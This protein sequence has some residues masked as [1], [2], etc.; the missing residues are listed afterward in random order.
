[1]MQCLTTNT[2]EEQSAHPLLIKTEKMVSNCLTKNFTIGN[3]GVPVC[4]EGYHMNHDG[5][6]LSKYRLK[7]RC[8]LASRKYDCS[9]EHPCSE[10]KYGRTVH[11]ATKDNPKLFNIPPRDSAE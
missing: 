9:C 11:V 8:P 3:D 1:M 7:F 10:A 4:K 6:E 2:V 5:S